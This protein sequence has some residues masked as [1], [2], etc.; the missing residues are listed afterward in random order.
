MRSNIEDLINLA[1]TK[2]TKLI[3]VNDVVPFGEN[4]NIDFFPKFTFFRDGPSISRKNAEKRRSKYTNLLKSYVD[5]ETIYYI[6]PL[7]K[8]CDAEICKAVIDGNLIYADGSPHFNK[9]GSLILN[10]LWL[11][12]LPEILF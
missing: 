6:D 7:P 3:L 4:Y 2:N 9:N 11:E 10:N 12:K 5:S 1:K 8:V